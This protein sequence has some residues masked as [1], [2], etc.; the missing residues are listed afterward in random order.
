MTAPPGD[1]PGGAVVFVCEVCGCAPGE[2]S[3]RTPLG[4]PSPSTALVGP[5][6]GLS[7]GG[8]GRMES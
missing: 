8:N 3:S 7:P 4:P 1:L 6:A 2:E 5:G